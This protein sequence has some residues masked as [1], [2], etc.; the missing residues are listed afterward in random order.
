[1]TDTN[2]ASSSLFRII[3]Q[4]ILARVQ[5]IKR[6]QATTNNIVDLQRISLD[7]LFFLR[8][9]LAKEEIRRL[10]AILKNGAR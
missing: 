3:D 2:S 9:Q 1:M 4:E 5:N 8:L 10:D 6:T 7:K